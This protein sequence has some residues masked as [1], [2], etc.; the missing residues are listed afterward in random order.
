MRRARR[1]RGLFPSQQHRPRLAAESVGSKANF[2]DRSL[3]Y[4]AF[5]RAACRRPRRPR[6]R[7]RGFEPHDATG[8]A[9]ERRARRMFCPLA[10]LRAEP[11]ATSRHDRHTFTLSDADLALIESPLSR[12]PTKKQRPGAQTVAL[13]IRFSYP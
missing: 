5:S 7:L 3:R 11:S 9:A 4:A 1:R 12:L 8:N 2:F 13:G 10:G 6:P